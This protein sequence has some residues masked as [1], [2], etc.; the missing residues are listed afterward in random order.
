MN[1]DNRGKTLYGYS[2]VP[3]TTAFEKPV[4]QKRGLIKFGDLHRAVARDRV[5]GAKS[6]YIDS[7]P[8][9]KLTPRS[10][11]QDETAYS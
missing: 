11:L 7:L 5:F 6:P 3:N 9:R 10:D 2:R 1:H 8:E 4:L